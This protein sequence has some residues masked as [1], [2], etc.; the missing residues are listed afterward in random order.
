MRRQY[1]HE[2]GPVKRGQPPS[3]TQIG[4]KRSTDLDGHRQAIVPSALAVDRELACTPIDVI[5]REHGD[6]A[7]PQPQPAHQ[8]DE[9]EVAAAGRGQWS[10]RSRAPP[11]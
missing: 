9:L 8:Q 4:C 10:Q 6:L 5:K 1:A 7:A 11:D 3:A 2:P